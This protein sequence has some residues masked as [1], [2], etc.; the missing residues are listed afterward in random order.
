MYSTHYKE[1]TNDVSK[2]IKVPI[3]KDPPKTPIKTPMA[4]KKD[5]TLNV[6]TLDE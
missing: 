2:A 6:P 3:A 5:V 1:D 4:E